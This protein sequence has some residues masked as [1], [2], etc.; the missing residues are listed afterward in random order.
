[1]PC[2]LECFRFPFPAHRQCSP[3]VVGGLGCGSNLSKSEEINSR[4]YEAVMSQQ[5]RHHLDYGECGRRMFGEDFYYLE[6]GENG[7]RRDDGQNFG[8]GLLGRIQV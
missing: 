5:H 6:W 7:L 4:A 8:E 1:M 3:G 2:P